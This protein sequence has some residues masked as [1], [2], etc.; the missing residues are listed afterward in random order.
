MNAMASTYEYLLKRKADLEVRMVEAQKRA[1]APFEG[2]L[3]AIGL[4]LGAI[5]RAGL[6]EGRVAVETASFAPASAPSRRGRRSRSTGD[7]ILMALQRGGAGAAA[8]E[9][10]QQLERRWSR[11]L[12]VS[13]I[14]QELQHLE[15]EGAVARGT[16]GWHRVRDTVDLSDAGT[17]DITRVA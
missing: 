9:I 15:S 4:A 6:V 2:E 7:M 5:E 13:V 8:S 3:K 12:P 11:T 17:V 1:Q 14:L 16:S 10:A